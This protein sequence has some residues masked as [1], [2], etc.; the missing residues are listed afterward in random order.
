MNIWIMFGL[1]VVC[2]LIGTTLLKLSDGFSK[3]FISFL[4]LVFY[5]GAITLLSQVTK[6]LDIGVV[7]AIWSGTGTAV[8]AIIGMALFGEELTFFKILFLG[9]IIM[10]MVGLQLSLGNR[11]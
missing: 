2:E 10:G 7:Y 4:T 1:A 5:S 9:L 6:Y 8:M 3:F 11:G